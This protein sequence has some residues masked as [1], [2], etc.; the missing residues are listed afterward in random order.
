ML[1]W[2]LTY[3]PDR[4]EY[5]MQIHQVRHEHLIPNGITTLSPVY[6]WS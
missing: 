2:V 5:L 3:H 6:R 4:S 1:T